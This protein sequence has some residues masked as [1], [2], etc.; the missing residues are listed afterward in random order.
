MFSVDYIDGLKQG[1]ERRYSESGLLTSSID[2]LD[3]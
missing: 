1:I 2:Y 3:N